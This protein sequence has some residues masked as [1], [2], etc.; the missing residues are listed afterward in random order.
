MD[1]EPLI[2]TGE[3]TFEPSIDVEFTGA[4][5]VIG[6]TTLEATEL[7][8]EAGVS[9]GPQD[10]SLV[11]KLHAAYVE[12]SVLAVAGGDTNIR[13]SA[14]KTTQFIG[15]LLRDLEIHRRRVGGPV[16]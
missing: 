11:T 2:V 9:P 15:R 13:Y 10:Q 5:T 3:T 8:V 6:G 14:R 12:A 16:G 4:L 1:T 7:G